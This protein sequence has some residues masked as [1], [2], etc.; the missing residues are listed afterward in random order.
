MKTLNYVVLFV[1]VLSFG[2]VSFGCGESDSPTAPSATTMAD[3]S[4]YAPV[5][6]VRT[7][8]ASFDAD[9]LQ[10]DTGHTGGFNAY[11]FHASY[12]GSMLNLVL[13]EDEMTG[14][15]AASKPHRNRLITVGICPSEPHHM[16]QACGDPIWQGSMRL[17]GRLELDPIP[18]ASCEGWIVVNAAELSDDI[19][20]GWRNA[21]CPSTDGDPVGSDG[22]GDEWPDYPEPEHSLPITVLDPTG[23][24]VD[25]LTF[26]EVIDISQGPG[27]VDLV[28]LS[29]SDQDSEGWIRVTFTLASA[30]D[31]NALAGEAPVNVVQAL[32]SVHLDIGQNLFAIFLSAIC[33]VPVVCDDDVIGRWDP[34]VYL[35]DSMSSIVGRQAAS[36]VRSVPRATTG[37]TFSFEVNPPAELRGSFV[38]ADFHISVETTDYDGDRYRYTRELEDGI[39]LPPDFTLPGIP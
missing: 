15:R 31:L 10:P 5:N 34:Q 21:P 19:Y 33:T 16:L 8:P 24:A 37:S 20:D 32:A 18:L 13:V 36:Y 12:D 17:A 27:S 35:T 38:P 7:T 25:Y 14:M 2:F 22:T 23:D 11:D 28:S 9:T 29:L 6:A 4:S 1:L 3:A 26:D 39:S 30:L